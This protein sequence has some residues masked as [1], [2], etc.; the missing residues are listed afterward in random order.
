MNKINA[1]IFALFFCNLA[2]AQN[3]SSPCL[4][5]LKEDPK[6]QVLWE[7]LPFDVTKG[8]PLEVLANN[9]KPTS[10]EKAA[11]SFFA[12]EGE[13]CL[14][15]GAEWRQQNYP[16]AIISLFNTYRVEMVSALADL[17]A[18]K[19]TYGELAK[20]RAKRTADLQNSVDVVVRDLEIQRAAN[21]K[22]RRE[23]AAQ[24][25]QAQKQAQ[26]Q[27]DAIAQQQRFS[28]QQAQQQQEESRRQAALQFLR[29]QKPYQVP[30][31]QMPIPQTTNCTAFGN[32]MNCTTR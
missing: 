18:G 12:S 2:F 28:E 3:P 6:V 26:E 9:S 19:T 23:A 22:Q 4:A 8:Q 15:L 31:Y 20:F 14:D 1:T 16:P 21:E 25:S 32:Q 27:R 17:Y 24:E 11:L 5:Q 10:K 13:R 29:N 7:K 30:L